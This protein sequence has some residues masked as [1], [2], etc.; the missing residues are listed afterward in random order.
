[1]VGILDF[2]ER[3]FCIDLITGMRSQVPSNDHAYP[4]L[5]VFNQSVLK[6]FSGGISG[7]VNRGSLVLKKT[8]HHLPS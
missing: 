8:L 7:T 1:M 6:G 2:C 4:D 5:S 3:L